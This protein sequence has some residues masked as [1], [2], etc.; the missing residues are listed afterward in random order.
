MSSL[1]VRI[2][3]A[4][5]LATISQAGLA[6]LIGVKRSAVTQWEHP[7]GTRPSVDHMIQIAVH[8][9]VGFEWIATGRGPSHV[10]GEQMEPAVVVDD[11]ARDQYES[12]A[13][14]YL[15]GLPQTKKKMVLQMLEILSR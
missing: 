4:R 12:Q 13:L 8:T 1:S 11:Y 3:R 10:N 6:R 7:A 14:L 2:R 5:S 9:G 15:R